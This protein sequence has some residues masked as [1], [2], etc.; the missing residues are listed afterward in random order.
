[1]FKRLTTLKNTI[2][3]KGM[4]ENLYINGVLKA[5]TISTITIPIYTIYNMS[6]QNNDEINELIDGMALYTYFVG[7]SVAWPLVSVIC[8]IKRKKQ[9]YG[10]F[11]GQVGKK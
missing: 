10:R 4:L 8:L 5:F 6:I 9:L 3:I 1:M 2:N 7:C 11:S